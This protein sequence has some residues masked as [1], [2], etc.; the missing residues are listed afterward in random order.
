MNNISNLIHAVD[1]G[2]VIALKEEFEELHREIVAYVKPVKDE[3]TGRYWYT[4][5]RVNPDGY[6]YHCVAAFVGEMGETKAALMTASLIAKWQPHTII[7]LGI[8]AGISDDVRVGDV[9]AATVVD[10]YLQNSKAVDSPGGEGFL[11]RMSGEPFR[12]SRGLIEEVRNFSLAFRPVHDAWQETASKQLTAELDE[13]QQ[14]ELQEI[15]KTD[16]VREKPLIELGHVACGPTVGAAE[17]FLDFVKSR[18]R[19]FLALEMESG[20]V[21]EALYHEADR[22]HSLVLRGISDYGDERKKDLDRFGSGHFRRYAIQNAIQLVWRL[23]ETNAF[24]KTSVPSPVEKAIPPKL[25][26]DI[27]SADPIQALSDPDPLVCFSAAKALQ[28][29]SDLA[30]K[31]IDIRTGSRVV[32]QAVREVLMT[33]P[34]ESAVV[35]MDALMNC[36]SSGETW[37]RALRASHYFTPAHRPFAEEAASYLLE[38]GTYETARHTLVA[39]GRMGCFAS[40]KWLAQQDVLGT[41]YGLQKCYDYALQGAAISFAL[42]ETEFDVKFESDSLLDL[43]RLPESQTD[44][45]VMENQHLLPLGECGMR[46]VDVIL[47]SW[48]GS[49]NSRI[50]RLGLEVLG[51]LRV[52]RTASKIETIWRRNRD[53]NEVGQ[54]AANA[55]WCIADPG[56]IKSMLESG[57]QDIIGP[58]LMS[59]DEESFDRLMPQVLAHSTMSWYA[60]RAIGL[61]RDR[62]QLSIL[63]NGLVSDY[64]DIRGTSALALARLGESEGLYR[65]FEESTNAGE[66]IFTALAVLHANLAKYETLEDQLRKDLAASDSYNFAA[67]AQMDILDVLRQNA[68]PQALRLAEAWAPFYGKGDVNVTLLTS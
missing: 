47:R 59:L 10:S 7:V 68:A 21:L 11:L 38:N 9:I 2:I 55:L 67:E 31:I 32:E 29:Q 14:K 17:S 64:F 23:M 62:D 13:K 16:L 43:I 1:I 6:Q 30:D 40:H 22:R 41:P 25:S 15:L 54:A 60:Y 50:Q 52:K 26:D 58:G 12:S 65:A 35:L 8:A 33:F 49:E 42:S 48:L 51:K 4:F 66:R 53:I 36:G 18:D 45:Y 44:L 39:L 27:V 20:G 61:R 3:T 37:S 5:N 34:E 24:K 57:V 56:S 46:H 63:R 28:G 19:K